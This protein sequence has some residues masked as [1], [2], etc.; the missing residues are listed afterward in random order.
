MPSSLSPSFV[1][2]F[3]HANPTR[4]GDD[5]VATLDLNAFALERATDPP[6]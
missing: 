2:S 5:H 4:C 3:I 1:L 6:A